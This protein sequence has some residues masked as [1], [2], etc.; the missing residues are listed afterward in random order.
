[1]VSEIIKKEKQPTSQWHT[2]NTHITQTGSSRIFKCMV[3]GDYSYQWT[4]EVSRTF[5]FTCPGAALPVSYHRCLYLCA[6]LST[7]PPPRHPALSARS[8]PLSSWAKHSFHFGPLKIN[9]S[10]SKSVSALIA[11]SWKNGKEVWKYKR[12]CF[13]LNPSLLPFSELFAPVG[14]IAH[15]RMQLLSVN[16]RKGWIQKK[17]HVPS[18]VLILCAYS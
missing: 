17:T 3:V 2:R 11:L 9:G 6:A 5:P 10:N 16:I 18:C 13:I 7:S 1:M 12:D 4:K 8:Q 15:E 14:E